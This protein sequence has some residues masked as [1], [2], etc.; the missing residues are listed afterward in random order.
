VAIIL[1]LSIGVVVKAFAWQIVLRRDGV[2]SKT[3][4]RHRHLERAAAP[5]LHRDRA[6]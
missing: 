4:G 3:A 1:P 5:A 2:V 6:S